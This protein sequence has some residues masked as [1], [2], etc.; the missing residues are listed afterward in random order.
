VPERVDL[1]ADFARAF[2]SAAPGKVEG[3]A[4]LADT[5]NTHARLWAGFDDLMIRCGDNE[6]AV[7]R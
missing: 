5:D 7:P 3:L 1:A 6:G 2:P 4:F